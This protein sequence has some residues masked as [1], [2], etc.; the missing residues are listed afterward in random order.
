MEG[1]SRPQYPETDYTSNW[2]LFC[3]L[4]RMYGNSPHSPSHTPS[5]STRISGKNLIQ[6]ALSGFFLIC[7][8]S[9][10]QTH[11]WNW[12][13]KTIFVYVKRGE[14]VSRLT[15]K[16]PEKTFKI[17]NNLFGR[18]VPFWIRRNRLDCKLETLLYEATISAIL[19]CDYPECMAILY[20]HLLILIHH[21]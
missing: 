20:L 1:L 11:P 14:W 15:L 4:P 10:L 18:S 2:K 17:V 7:F 19:A 8:N 3:W 13:L 16:S 5:S 9:I 12:I 6:I 21:Q